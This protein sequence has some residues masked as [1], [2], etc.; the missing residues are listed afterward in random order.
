MNRWVVCLMLLAL[1]V[2][3]CAAHRRTTHLNDLRTLG[4]EWKTQT[5]ATRIALSQK[6]VSVLPECLIRT[7]NFGMVRWNDWEHPSYKLYRGDLV[8]ILGQPGQ[9]FALSGPGESW[10]L[11]DVSEIPSFRWGPTAFM[12]YD[13]GAGLDGVQKELVITL[14][15][16]YVVAGAVQTREHVE[17]SKQMPDGKSLV[18]PGS[19]Q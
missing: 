4:A 5:N 6:I 3:G 15:N 19:T 11:D 18:I 16:D 7:K 8:Q 14:Y 9:K 10:L 2:T 13:L 12:V 17:K 1:H